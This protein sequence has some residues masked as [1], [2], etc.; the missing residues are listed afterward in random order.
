MDIKA[1]SNALFPND[2]IF[3]S[4]LFDAHQDWEVPIPGFFIIAA[5]RDIHSLAD[6]TV[7]E[8]QE[9]FWLLRAI[10]AGMREVLGIEKVLLVENE[11][12]QWQFHMWL[13]P[14]HAWM[15]Q[16]GSKTWSAQLAIEYAIQHMQTE[17][18]FSAIHDAVQQMKS[19]IR[20]YAP[21]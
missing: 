16:W 10:R 21:R 20:S 6:F 17:E 19:Y 8:Q 11:A 7:A 12:S 3:V 2:K 1:P 9:F 18:N 13:F 14:W 5:Q 15:Q 4:D